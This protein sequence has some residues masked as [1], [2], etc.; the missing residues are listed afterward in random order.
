MRKAN[1]FCVLAALAG[2]SM[3]GSIA[4][5]APDRFVSV[6]S[7]NLVSNGDSETVAAGPGVVNFKTDDTGYLAGAQ[8]RAALTASSS[9]TATVCR[10]AV[11]GASASC[12]TGTPYTV[13]AGWSATPVVS[14]DAI[15]ASTNNEA[16]FY[17]QRINV[18][19]GSVTVIG[20]LLQGVVVP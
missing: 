15:A 7:N 1:W 20:H 12:T 2:L 4:A 8:V 18:T 19:G 16:D 11:G 14:T 13:P 3:H 17:Y 6:Y 10:R 9:V 5:A